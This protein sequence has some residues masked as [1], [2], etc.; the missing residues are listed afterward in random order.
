MG[1]THPGLNSPELFDIFQ[2]TSSWDAL[3]IEAVAGLAEAQRRMC[4]IAT[5]TPGDYFIFCVRT[6]RVIER[7][8]NRRAHILRTA[9]STNFKKVG[10][11]RSLD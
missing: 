5:D 1:T 9:L 6:E 4:D 3:W 10:F 8:R 11:R 2:G 7:I